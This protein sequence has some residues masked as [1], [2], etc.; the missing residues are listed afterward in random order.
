MINETSIQTLTDYGHEL[1]AAGFEVWLHRF[2]EGYL[3]YRNPE[4]GDCGSLQYS[5]FEGWGHSMP[6]VPSREYGSSM[7]IEDPADP[8]TVE[9]ARQCAQ[10]TNWNKA[11][12]TRLANAKDRTWRSADAIPLHP[13]SA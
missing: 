1:V 10:P 7:Y 11:V 2:G 8:W 12:G 3:T 6:I 5:Y 13:V 9:A 4:T